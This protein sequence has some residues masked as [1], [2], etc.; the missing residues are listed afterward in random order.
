MLQTV[1]VSLSLH[2]QSRKRGTKDVREDGESWGL[3]PRQ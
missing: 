2:M 1:L 3:V